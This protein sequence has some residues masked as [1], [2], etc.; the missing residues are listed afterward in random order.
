MNLQTMHDL[1]KTCVEH[2]K[3]IEQE[4]RIGKRIA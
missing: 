3:E 2:G 1:T 4:V